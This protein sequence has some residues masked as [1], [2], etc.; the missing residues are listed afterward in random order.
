MHAPPRPPGPPVRRGVLPVV[1]PI[2]N[3]DEARMLEKMV[4]LC[5]LRDRLSPSSPRR[6]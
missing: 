2:A 3:V 4:L 5:E 1:G 6:R